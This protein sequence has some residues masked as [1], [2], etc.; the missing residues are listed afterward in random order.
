MARRVMP[1]NSSDDRRRCM[2][3]GS[4]VN[5]LSLGRRRSLHKSATISGDYDLGADGSS[6]GMACSPLVCIHNAYQRL[7]E[8][9]I[10]GVELVMWE[11]SWFTWL[12]G[13]F[14]PLRL[15]LRLDPFPTG[16]D[17][18]TRSALFLGGI[19]RAVAIAFPPCKMEIKESQVDRRSGVQ[20]HIDYNLIATTLTC[21][22]QSH[23]QLFF[24]ASA[25]FTSSSKGNISGKGPT[26]V[27]ANGLIC[28]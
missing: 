21:F 6:M 7:L 20:C 12:M 28:P 22:I 4:L 10:E 25:A 1:F 3:S 14:W 16:N 24:T 9:C 2:W 18:G 17:V 27:I 15:S 8:G 23:V 26:G 19:G 11:L 5:T 13:T